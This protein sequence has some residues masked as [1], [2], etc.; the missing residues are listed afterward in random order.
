[1][2]LNAIIY[3]NSLYIDAAMKALQADGQLSIGPDIRARLS[4]LIWEHINVHGSYPFTRP[5]APGNLREL[6]D[7]G[8]R[9]RTG[10]NRDPCPSAGRQR[11][12][13][14]GQSASPSSPGPHSCPRAGRATVLLPA[15]C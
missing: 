4:P 12:R 2:G 15:A 10:L 14:C 3:W 5:E 7:E 1:M 8:R 13:C 11:R 6:R 9:R